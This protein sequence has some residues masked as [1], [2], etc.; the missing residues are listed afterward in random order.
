MTSYTLCSGFTLESFEPL[1]TRKIVKICEELKKK[2]G[3]GYEFEPD[4]SLE[5]G[6]EFKS[7]PGKISKQYKSFR[8]HIS[9]FYNIGKWPFIE[10]NTFL[11]W[12]IEKEKNEI[13]F[14]CSEISKKL[15]ISSYLKAINGA[16]IWTI[17]E[18]KIFSQCFKL[19][20]FETVGEIPK[21][22]FLST[23]DDIKIY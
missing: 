21:E 14:E 10:N 13:I 18:L 15:V 4:I 6:I 11:K 22:I 2:F 7:W 23:T 12:I 9:H 20:G 17:D 8:F 1:T 5:G 3:E 16:P 19:I